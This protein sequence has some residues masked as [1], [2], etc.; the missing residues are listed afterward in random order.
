[1]S[2]IKP[3]KHEIDEMLESIIEMIISGHTRV[4]IVRIY[5]APDQP[6]RTPRTI[7][8]YL[9]RARKEI[10]KRNKPRIE[11][12]TATAYARYDDLYKKNID[13]K[14]YR[15]ARQVQDS[16]NKL[17]GLNAPEKI[18]VDSKTTFNIEIK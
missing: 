3:S 11:A 2:G 6:Q 17:A 1:M 8:N 15:E 13:A 16:L 10:A 14:D 7:D 12:L 9:A 5:M 4:E 18:A